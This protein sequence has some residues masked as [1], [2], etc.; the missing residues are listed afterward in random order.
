MSNQFEMDTTSL[1]TVKPL[2]DNG[3]YAGYLTGAAIEGKEGKQF[4]K[5]REIIKYTK[6]QN[7]VA[8]GKYELTGM[9]MYSVALTS[10]KAIATLLNDEPRI[11]GGMMF[12]TFTDK[13]VLDL[14]NNTQL[15]Q[16][17]KALDLQD[18]N[19][20]E[21]VDF[22]F[23]E[24]ILDNFAPEELVSRSRGTF[25]TEAILLSEVPDIVTMLNGAEYAKQLVTI[26]CQTINDMPVLAK[27]NKQ[28]ERDNAA[29]Q[30]NVLDMGSRSAPF[31]GILPYEEGAE[32]DLDEE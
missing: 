10:K 32:D 9:L 5:V 26:I 28:A 11:F 4:F 24:D 12:F 21:G 2:L 16:L 19:F 8:T 25:D 14:G 30:V 18:T 23:N 3:V 15:G 1:S 22:E 7:P 31:C 17:L 20:G 13:H 6:G 27:V 29:V